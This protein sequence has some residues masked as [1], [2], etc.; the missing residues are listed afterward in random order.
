[1]ETN[2]SMVPLVD[3]FNLAMESLGAGMYSSLMGTF[4]IPS[5]INYLGS[6]SVGKYIVTVI[7]RT[8]PWVLPS[9]HEPQVHLS[10]VEE[11]IVNIPPPHSIRKLQSLQ[12]KSN[13][14]QCFIVNYANITKGF[15]CMLK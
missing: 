14:L 4:D 6:T 2:E 13:F 9:Y 15:M 5:L 8:G 11:A 10:I 1:M 7:D 12:G 3:Q